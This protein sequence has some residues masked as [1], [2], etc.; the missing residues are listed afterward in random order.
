[1]TPNGHNS[2]ALRAGG[3]FPE[4]WPPGL[5]PTSCSPE[6]ARPVGDYFENPREA[7]TG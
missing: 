4:S 1:M 6:T 7:A 5:Y 2:L 3:G